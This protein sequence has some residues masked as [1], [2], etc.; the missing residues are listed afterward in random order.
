[1]PSWIIAGLALAAFILALAAPV[2]PYFSSLGG[3]I[4]ISRWMLLGMWLLISA[5]LT[6]LLSQEGPDL[7]STEEISQADSIRIARES[8]RAATD[9]VL[10]AADSARMDADSIAVQDNRLI[11]Y[12]VAEDVVRQQLRTPRT[13]RFPG[14]EEGRLGHVTRID[15]H[16]Y[17]IRS[18]VDAEDSSG[19]PTRTPWSAEVE[20]VE[21]DEWV[22]RNVVI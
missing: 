20:Q 5:V 11:A 4:P 22:V 15:E 8:A 21:L 16:V 17:E 2:L 3:R 19:S 6:S 13:V 9:S 7:I 1:M 18:Y 10:V 12:R 14:P